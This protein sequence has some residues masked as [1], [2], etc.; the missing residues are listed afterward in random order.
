MKI[1]ISPTFFKN[2]IPIY[3]NTKFNKN[4]IKND[5]Q[6]IFSNGSLTIEI[7][8]Q[9]YLQNLNC[10]IVVK[11]LEYFYSKMSVFRNLNLKFILNL[12]VNEKEINFERIIKYKKVE[13]LYGIN[14]FTKGIEISFK[15]KVFDS[16]KT[17]L[18]NSEVYLSKELL[19]HKIYK[20]VKEGKIK[21]E[22]LEKINVCKED[23]YKT[24][25]SMI[26]SGIL[27]KKDNYI[28]INEIL[29]F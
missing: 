21:I 24:L 9:L 20:I 4:I 6:I 3:E 27:I 28:M 19:C 15:P 17:S 10:Y 11:N 25:K 22:E 1:F 18:E 13:K 5:I 26:F 23:L 2:K 14:N 8:K 7:I 16:I 29:V 12:K